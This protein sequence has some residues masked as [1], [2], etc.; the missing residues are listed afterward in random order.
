MNQWTFTS[1]AGLLLG[2]LML[3]VTM[4]ALAAE[5]HPGQAAF[6]AAVAKKHGVDERQI[7]ELLD[8]AERKQSII[9]AMRR[10]AES[11]PWPEYRALFLTPLRIGAGVA[12][13]RNNRELLETVADK[14]GVDPQYIVAIIGVETNYGTRTGDYRVL[15][16]LAT[17]AFHYPPRQKYFR[18]ELEKF[19]TMPA[20]QL[21]GPLLDIKGSYAGAMG[22]GQFMPTSVA[23]YARDEDGDG[24]INLVESL[25]DIVG[26]VANYLARHGWQ[27]GQPVAVDATAAKGAEMVR[28]DH[29]KT[30]YTVGQLE[31]RGFAPVSSVAADTAATLLKMDG[32]DGDRYWLT[33][34]NFYVI[35][36]YNRSPLY[37][38]AVNHLAEA[39]AAGSADMV[40]TGA[41]PQSGTNV[42][43]TRQVP[44][45]AR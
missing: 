21:P 7:L 36:R 23:A 10:P 15:D 9:D 34:N 38:M 20:T 4:P 13:Y 28:T 30:L 1:A 31:A 42:S 25:P 27:R 12:F 16:A 3:V 33:F 44:G 43:T 22:W 40:E 14:Y 2:T 35:T 6:A 8:Q 18:G 5:K 26:S 39:I 24:H 45:N 19:L 32:T 11:K 41:E 29:S 17:L 37:A